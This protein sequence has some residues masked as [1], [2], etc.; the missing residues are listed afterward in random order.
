MKQIQVTIEVIAVVGALSSIAYHFLALYS[1]AAFLRKRRV[2]T[3]TSVADLPPV[4]ILKPLKGIDPGM[5][6]SFRTH[7]LQNYP[8]YEI[9]FGVSD[10]NDPAITEVERLK[11]EFP[12]RN[13]QLMVCAKHLGANIKISNLVQMLPAARYEHL[14]VNDSDIRVPPDYL[15]TVIAPLADPAT[16]MVTCLYCAVAGDTLGSKLEALG[17]NTDFSAGVLVAQ[18][19]EGIRFGLGSTLALRRQT[20]GEIGGFES[21]LDYLA[22]DYEIG[23]RVAALNLKVELSQLVVETYLPAYK[24]P[25]FLH[26]QLRWG[27]AIRDS[28]PWGY[29]GLAFTFALMWSLIALIVSGGALWAWAL[30]AMAAGA[31]GAAAVLVGRSVLQDQTLRPIV[32]LLPLRD[33]IGA[34]IWLASFAGHNVAW[35]GDSFVLKKGK[36]ARI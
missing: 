24:F 2:G 36:L 33:F 11:R 30:F 1:A 31:R 35:R 26:H 12:E 21:M 6:E 20:L 28:R 5:Y 13:I 29:L 3:S 19:L 23:K 25:D 16:G 4:S 34:A 15:Q 32:W 14:I 17:V 8:A 27:R 9:I 10:P 18:K 22:D 7:C